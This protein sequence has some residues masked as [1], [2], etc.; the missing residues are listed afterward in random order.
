M[1]CTFILRHAASIISQVW[2]VV[3]KKSN[4]SLF[5]QMTD[6][7]FLFKNNLISLVQDQL[8]DPLGKGNGWFLPPNGTTESKA[9]LTTLFINISS[10]RRWKLYPSTISHLEFLWQRSESIFD[11]VEIFPEYQQLFKMNHSYRHE[12]DSKFYSIF[13]FHSIQIWKLCLIKG[14]KV[15]KWNWK[16]TFKRESNTHALWAFVCME[17]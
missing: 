16:F 7:I 15:V 17:R 9:L 14:G 13:F 11:S 10:P 12:T 3:S 5:I 2:K 4:C 6:L 1:N 8:Q